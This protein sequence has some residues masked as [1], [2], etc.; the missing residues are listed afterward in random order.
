[1]VFYSSVDAELIMFNGEGG[2]TNLGD[3]VFIGKEAISSSKSWAETVGVS[4]FGSRHSM[5]YFLPSVVGN[6]WRAEGEGL[7]ENLSSIHYSCQSISWEDEKAANCS[8]QPED[9]LIFAL[10][11]N[12][13]NVGAVMQGSS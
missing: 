3:P 7:L 10:D 2:P 1:M 4:S 12:A 11:G 8:T 9:S 13:G 5:K 6:Q